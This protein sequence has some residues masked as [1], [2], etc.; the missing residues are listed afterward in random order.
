MSSQY[1]YGIALIEYYEMNDPKAKG[2]FAI[3]GRNP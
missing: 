3:T 2:L 1:D